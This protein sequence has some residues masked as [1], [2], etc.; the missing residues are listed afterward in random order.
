MPNLDGPIADEEAIAAIIRVSGGNFRLL[1]RLL[2]QIA[3]IMEFNAPHRVTVD[4]VEAAR[5]SLVVGGA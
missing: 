5:E 3:R 2:A 4:I 1:G